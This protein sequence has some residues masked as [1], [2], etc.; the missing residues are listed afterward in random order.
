MAKQFAVAGSWGLLTVGAALVTLENGI[1]EIGKLEGAKLAGCHRCCWFKSGMKVP[2]KLP[3]HRLAMLSCW[4]LQT[5][6]ASEPQG[7]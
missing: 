2:G 3:V 6:V 5:W 1:A 4:W 7:R